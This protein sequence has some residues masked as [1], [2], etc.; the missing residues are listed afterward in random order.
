M[1][2]R[3]DAAASPPMP[4]TCATH[5]AVAQ[6]FADAARDFGRAR[7]CGG[8]QRRHQR[9]A[10]AAGAVRRRHF[11]QPGRGQHRRRLQ[12]A[13][14]GRAPGGR[15]RRHRRTDDLDGASRRARTAAPTWPARRRSSRWCGRWP[16][17]WRA[18]RACQR[19]GARAGRHRPLPRRQDRRDD[20]PL[21]GHEPLQPRRPACRG[22]RGG[23]LPVL[24]R[25]SWV[26]GQIVQPNGGMV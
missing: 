26:H 24:A 9:A 14:R 17:R 15:R 6:V 4:A 18:R 10:G 23:E 12:R 2:P 7:S 16:R 3:G 19:R 5:G 20:R 8:G 21:G 25:A 1:A 11:P 22:G 13:A